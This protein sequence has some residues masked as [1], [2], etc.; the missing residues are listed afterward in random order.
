MYVRHRTL[1]MAAT[2]A[3][4]SGI[5][6]ILALIIRRYR[7]GWIDALIAKMKTPMTV[8]GIVATTVL[9]LSIV[10]AH[11]QSKSTSSI[12]WVYKEASLTL[13]LLVLLLLFLKVCTVH[14]VKEFNPFT[15]WLIPIMQAP[16]SHFVLLSLA[17]AWVT[18]T[19]G[20]ATSEAAMMSRKMRKRRA[21]YRLKN[22]HAL[23]SLHIWAF[24]AT[25]TMLMF[26]SVRFARV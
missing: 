17:F 18:L 22:A 8:E 14:K 3:E 21:Q 12:L 11:H 13:L 19:I 23:K 10:L 6:L 5:V 4:I 7:I 9:I 1:W 16:T 25:L 2:A 24:V 20:R 15:A 26:W